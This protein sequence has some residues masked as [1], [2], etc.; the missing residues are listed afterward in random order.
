MRTK[1]NKIHL[2]FQRTYEMEVLVPHDLLTRQIEQ[3]AQGF[4]DHEIEFSA[5]DPW[6]FIYSTEMIELPPSSRTDLSQVAHLAVVDNDLTSIVPPEDADWWVATE[7]ELLYE[8]QH[9]PN[10]AQLELFAK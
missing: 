8:R 9:E 4:A 1:F 2:T 7:D 5:V 3:I 10:P 6:S